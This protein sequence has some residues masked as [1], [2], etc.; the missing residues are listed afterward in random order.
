MFGRSRESAIDEELFQLKFRSK[1]LL[2]SA[3]NYKKQEKAYY[4][5]AKNALK[6]GDDRTAGLYVKQSVQFQ[7]ASH[8]FSQLGLNLEIVETKV[9]EAVQSG[10]VSDNIVNTLRLLNSHLRPRDALDK[11][12]RM[13][14]AFEDIMVFTDSINNSM[15]ETV[16]MNSS[17]NELESNILND[18]KSEVS[19]DAQ[20]DMMML[21]SINSISTQ[22]GLKNSN[23]S[24]F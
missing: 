8:K 15:D 13:D 7:N 20:S 22:N 5:K 4:N 17:S 19:M 21:P 18:L 1:T 6:K 16:A 12:A 24:L 3:N 10:T 23:T 11:I 9:R 14:K 2:K